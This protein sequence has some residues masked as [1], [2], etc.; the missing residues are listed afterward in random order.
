MDVA[1]GG[2]L[3]DPDTESVAGQYPGGKRIGTGV[4][5][6]LFINE[7][8]HRTHTRAAGRP[9][10]DGQ[11][12]QRPDQPDRPPNRTPRQRRGGDDCMRHA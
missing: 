5:A 7:A 12:Q 9:G 1:S 10:G 2:P 6:V 11:T 3:A 8:D 4:H